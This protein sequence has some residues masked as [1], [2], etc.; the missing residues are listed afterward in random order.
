MA[1][2]IRKNAN[3]AAILLF[4]LV[5]ATA[6]LSAP[7]ATAQQASRQMTIRQARK[8]VVMGLKTAGTNPPT[9]ISNIKVSESSVVFNVDETYVYQKFGA[10]IA[11]GQQLVDLRTLGT[12]TAKPLR[13]G[14]VFLLYMDGKALQSTVLNF[15]PFGSL[16]GKHPN[17]LGIF[18]LSAEHAQGFVDAMNQL[19]SFARGGGKAQEELE[20]RDFQ[21]K[22]TAWR[23]LATKPPLPEAARQVQVLA[24]NAFREKQFDSAIEHYENGL[25]IYPVWPEGQFNVALLYAELKQYSDAIEHMRAYLELVP[26]APDAQASRD[27]MLIWQDKLKQQTSE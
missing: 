22:A 15:S 11:T 4:L 23:A 24:E 21:Q 19:S 25:D 18:A 1:A 10:C 27:Q 14:P 6:L 3:A 17:I 2:A 13:T 7:G 26:N 5:P 20:W 12:L 9:K 16:C 8:A